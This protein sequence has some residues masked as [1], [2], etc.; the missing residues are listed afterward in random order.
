MYT[1]EYSWT[2]E[3]LP[4]RAQQTEKVYNFPDGE[5]GMFE[6]VVQLRKHRVSEDEVESTRRERR[7]R[8]SRLEIRAALK[9]EYFA[10]LERREAGESSSG[11]AS[12]EGSEEVAIGGLLN[13]CRVKVLRAF[14][15]SFSAVS[16]PI[17]ASK[18]SFDLFCSIT[19][20]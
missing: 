8:A 3:V 13:G 7:P 17:F 15:G 10:E 5:G 4:R 9:E 1:S 12:P 6:K 20:F 16:T 18:Y 19:I 11:S 14:R 2:E